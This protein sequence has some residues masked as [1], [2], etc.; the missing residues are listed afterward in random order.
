MYNEGKSKKHNQFISVCRE[1]FVRI[2]IWY[3]NWPDLN[4]KNNKEKI[5]FN[6]MYVSVIAPHLLFQKGIEKY[7]IRSRN[8]TLHLKGIQ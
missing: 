8:K 2:I 1:M 7:F 4:I 6:T 5:K 3:D